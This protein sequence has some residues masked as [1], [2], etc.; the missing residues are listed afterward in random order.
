MPLMEY[1]EP[2]ESPVT[3]ETCVA[4]TD[5]AAGQRK[6]HLLAVCH[7][8]ILDNPPPPKCVVFI[9]QPCHEIL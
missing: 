1:E 9:V 5:V 4:A 8:E 7:S 2:A 3:A 6:L